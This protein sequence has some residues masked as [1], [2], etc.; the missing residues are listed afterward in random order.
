MLCKNPVAISFIVFFNVLLSACSSTSLSTQQI[1]EIQLT[2]SQLLTEDSASFKP[3]GLA[4]DQ[5]L[6]EESDIFKLPAAI[7]RELDENIVNLP[8]ELQRFQHLRNW[9]FDY[10]Q[11]HEYDPNVTVAVHKLDVVKKINCLS[12]SV[13]FLAAA[14]HVDIPAHI[15]VVYAPTTWDSVNNTWIQVQHINVT[16]NINGLVKIGTLS[17]REKHKLGLGMSA[18]SRQN[19]LGVNFNYTVDINTNI[20]EGEYDTKTLTDS[21]VIS[22]FYNNKAAAR[23]V[24]GQYDQ[25][26]FYNKK[27]L[28]ADLLSSEAWNN[29]GVLFSKTGQSDSAQM[30]FITALNISPDA[31]YLKNNLYASYIRTGLSDE[32]KKLKQFINENRESNPY[33][34]YQLG[35]KDLLAKN[36]QKAQS[37]FKQAIQLKSNEGLFYLALAESQF[38]LNQ[39]SLA[40]K[41]IE[42]AAK[43]GDSFGRE[44][45]SDLT[46]GTA[47][48]LLSSS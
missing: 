29:L 48:V 5:A 47:K 16:G 18:N 13:L 39:Q 23:I 19:K 32:P 45:D 10:I 41:N 25:A 15:Q 27:A 6:L 4:S 7:K 35:K 33:Y 37:H 24:G 2:L 26:F 17:I 14:R 46:T 28:K 30:A 3:I 44:K 34:H 22:R 21:E 8:T 9:A 43:F 11:H 38:G 1:D 40:L 31:N 36:F 42:R 20:V 12:F